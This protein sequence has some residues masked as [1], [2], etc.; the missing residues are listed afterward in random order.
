VYDD[1]VVE[2]NFFSQ[3]GREDILKSWFSKGNRPAANQRVQSILLSEGNQHLL[4]GHEIQEKIN[5]GAGAGY[6]RIA[7]AHQVFESPLSLS[8]TPTLASAIQW[9]AVDPDA[10]KPWLDGPAFNLGLRNL[11]DADKLF[12]IGTTFAGHVPNYTTT[13][14]DA[15][16]IDTAHHLLFDIYGIAPSDS[17]LYLPERTADGQT[18]QRLHDLQFT[19]TI[20]DQREHIE[21]WFGRTEALGNNGYRINRIHGIDTFIIHDSLSENIFTNTDG[22]AP[23]QIRRVLSRKSRSGEQQ[24]AVTLLSTLEDFTTVEQADA[25]ERNLR[26]L[27]NRPW[28]E[29][30]TPQDLIDRNWFAIDRGAPSLPLVSKNFVQYASQGSYDNWYFGNADRE[31]LAGKTFERTPGQSLPAPFGQIGQTGL[32]QDAWQSIFVLDPADGIGQLAHATAGAALFTTAFHDQGPVDLRKFSTGDYINPATG[33]EE[34]ADFSAT[35]QAHFRHAALYGDVAN[36]AATG[37]SLSSAVAVARDLTLDGVDNYLLYNRYVFA[38][39]DRLGG[40][41][42]ASW[43]RDSDTGRVFQTTGTLLT[44][45]DGPN[46]LEGE[47]NGTARRTSGFKDWFASGDGGSSY[48]NDPYDASLATGTETGWTLTSSDGS[49][50]KSITLADDGHTLNATYDVDASVGTLFIRFGLSPDLRQLMVSGQSY[51][52]A[53]TDSGGDVRITTQGPQDLVSTRLHYAGNGYNANWIDN[54]TDDPDDRFD[55]VNLRDQAL[56]QQLEFSGSG[57]FSIGLELSA[58]ANLSLDTDSDGLP[59]WWESLHFEDETIAL[60]GDDGDGDGLSNLQEFIVGTNPKLPNVYQANLGMTAAQD[61]T[62]Q[63]QTIE[64]RSYTVYYSHNLI[65][66]DIAESGIQG[67][68]GLM[69]W[70]DDGSQTETHPANEPRRFYRIQVDLPN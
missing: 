70:T 69:Q 53:P 55:T 16:N 51:L 13:A 10:G 15:A 34:L 18:F 43:V 17:L 24:Q 38:V 40:R 57:Q 22:G 56:T 26:W 12:L 63:F 58:T 5:D 30:V 45:A 25:Y 44:F 2:N 67:T 4:P 46:D 31:G 60:P 66:W 21:S 64:D 1:R 20:L 48:V 49:I 47:E 62:L 3:A 61:T 6:H 35:A 7:L 59:N 37:H 33:T 19:H 9:A 65:G 36:W 27:A 8:I 11:A 54:A 52:T 50:A 23:T 41:L 42:L 28:I 32:S 29:V 14:F 39:F 68:G